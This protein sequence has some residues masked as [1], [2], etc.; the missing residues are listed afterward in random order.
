M[1]GKERIINI[2]NHKPV[3]RVGLSEHF[4]TDTHKEYVA[5]GHLKPD[6]SFED[7]FDLD[8]QECWAFNMI[9]DLRGMGFDE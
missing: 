8:I 2:L 6:E 5:L 3:D 1:T 7:H 4:W 9:A